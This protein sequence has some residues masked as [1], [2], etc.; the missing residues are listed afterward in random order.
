MAPSQLP[1]QSVE[2]RQASRST[3]S[4]KSP[5]PPVPII[6]NNTAICHHHH[7]HHHSTNSTDNTQYIPPSV[8]LYSTTTTST[9]NTQYVRPVILLYTTTTTTNTTNMYYHWYAPPFSIMN[10]PQGD[11]EFSI[12]DFPGRD[13]AKSWDPRIF[14]NGISL[15]FLSRD[16]TKKKS[17]ISRGYHLSS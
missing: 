6:H 9:K 13:F 16:F 17:S 10:R 8:L 12:S 14:Q 15:K 1:P 11:Q 4:K 2:S 5:P 3:P 7:H